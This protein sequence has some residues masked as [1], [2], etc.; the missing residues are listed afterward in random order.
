MNNIKSILPSDVRVLRA[1]NATEN[2]LVN[3]KN[4]QKFTNYGLTIYGCEKRNLGE[5]KEMLGK[6]KRKLNGRLRE[7]YLSI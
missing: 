4:K 2:Y 3:C 7:L 6:D 5:Y 1:I